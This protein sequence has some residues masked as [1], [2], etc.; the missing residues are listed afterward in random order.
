MLGI[1]KAEGVQSSF[2]VFRY[3]ILKVHHSPYSYGDLL[4]V[5]GVPGFRGSS[6]RNFI[7]LEPLDD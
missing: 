6:K 5:E 7:L 3:R 4:G 1:Y 2:K